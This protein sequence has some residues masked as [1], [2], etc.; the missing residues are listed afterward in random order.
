M[1][2]VPKF[3]KADPARG[4]ESE[5]L[6]LKITPPHDMTVEE[7]MDSVHLGLAVHRRL[8]TAEVV[9]VW[10]GDAA[11]GQPVAHLREM[12]AETLD[13]TALSHA[14]EHFMFTAD[15]SLEPAV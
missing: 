8:S 15:G 1:F 13:A 2:D 6:L 11:A 14:R 5:S 3:V 10:L 4:R 9:A 12:P 7:I